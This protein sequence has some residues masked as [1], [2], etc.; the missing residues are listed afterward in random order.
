VHIRLVENNHYLH[1]AIVGHVARGGIARWRRGHHVAERLL[2]KRE[3]RGPTVGERQR[4]V[5]SVFVGR[6]GDSDAWRELGHMKRDL[7]GVDVE[8]L[9]TFHKLFG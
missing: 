8:W 1:R 3:A 5:Q 4:L 7:R 9:F 2:G 6:V